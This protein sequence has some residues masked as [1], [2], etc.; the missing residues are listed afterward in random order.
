[1]M[2]FFKPTKSFELFIS[3]YHLKFKK[4]KRTGL[5]GCLLLFDFGSGL[6]GYS[7]FLPWPLYG[8]KSLELQ[9]EEI[10]QGKF[11][12]RFL[13]A[14]QQA[15]LDARARR[16][17]RNLFFSLKIP[18]SHFLIDNLL[19][20]RFSKRLLA[21]K[22]IKAKMQPFEIL[23]Q[24]KV[25]KELNLML[26]DIKWRFDLNKNSWKEWE[27]SLSF[28]KDRIDFVE[29]PKEPSCIFSAEDWSQLPS[30]KIKIAKPS[31]DSF[32]SLARQKARWKRLVFTHSFDHP[33]GQAVSA[34]WAGL[35][36]KYHPQFFETGAFLNF[37]L[38][39]VKAYEIESKGSAFINPNGFGF[40][41]S[42]ALKN[43][44]WQKWI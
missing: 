11:S 38:E 39:T 21:F 10:Q 36:Y 37:Q 14:K 17:K 2:F 29:D 15:F 20:F 31:R 27:S 35:F 13:I 18:P 6:R 7:D 3:K 34:F 26:K 16:E 12:Q 32:M 43:E 24:V 4:L 8:E 42:K 22:I 19:N 44:N 9:L 41:F 1:M 23:E 30:A 25:L 28:L 5:E 33:L 40:G